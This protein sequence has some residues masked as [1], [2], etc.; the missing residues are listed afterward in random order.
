MEASMRGPFD[1]SGG[2]TENSF[3]QRWGA[4]FLVLPV[5]LVITLIGLAIVQPANTNWIADEVMAEF[6]GA[7]YGPADVAPTQLA[8]AVR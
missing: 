1:K 7:N 6:T 5:L 8:K 2:T 4:G 3:F